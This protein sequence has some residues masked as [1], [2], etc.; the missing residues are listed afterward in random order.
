MS[1]TRN[2]GYGS[3]VAR[4]PVPRSTKSQCRNNSPE[5]RC[6]KHLGKFNISQVQKAVP[7][8]FVRIKVKQSEPARDRSD[9]HAV[10][11][12]QRLDLRAGKRA[13]LRL[14]R[15]RRSRTNGSGLS[16]PADHEGRK[17]ESADGRPACPWR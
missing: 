1:R 3:N 12:V 9:G 6:G 8:A 5:R 2:S 16:V 17:T 14:L 15:S 7:R 4:N 13:Q 11:A 10:T